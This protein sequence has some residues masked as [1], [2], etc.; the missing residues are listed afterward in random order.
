[1]K[2]IFLQS[3]SRDFSW[4]NDYY[5][6]VFIQG[7]SKAKAH[8]YSAIST[9]KNNP[10]IGQAIHNTEYRKMVIYKTPFS[11]IYYINKEENEI[12]IVRI[13]D[14]RRKSINFNIGNEE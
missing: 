7:K 14:N 13:W 3:S 12:E 5:D 8:F 11:F 6:N 4:F 9:L 2:I 1:M 10:Y